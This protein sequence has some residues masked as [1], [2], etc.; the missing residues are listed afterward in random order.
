VILK[1][2]SWLTAVALVILSADVFAWNRHGHMVFGS[3]AYH[4]LTV[5]HP[6]LVDEILICPRHFGPVATLERLLG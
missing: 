2:A 4:E 3:I 5:S 6:D 1:T